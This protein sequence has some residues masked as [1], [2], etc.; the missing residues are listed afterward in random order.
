MAH[1]QKSKIQNSHFLSYPK[2]NRFYRAFSFA[3]VRCFGIAK[4]PTKFYIYLT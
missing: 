3:T 4:N 1:D 2:R